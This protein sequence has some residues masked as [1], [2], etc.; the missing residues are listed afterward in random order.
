M[1][2]NEITLT[3]KEKQ[4]AFDLVDSVRIAIGQ[5]LGLY[6]KCVSDTDFWEADERNKFLVNYVA[7]LLKR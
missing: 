5:D 1:I 4:L 2:M 7:E 3:R 6:D